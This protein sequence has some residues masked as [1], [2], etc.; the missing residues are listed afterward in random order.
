MDQEPYGQQPK[1]LII[2][3]INFFSFL[4]VNLIIP[5]MALYASTL[6][7]NPGIIGL[8]IGLYSITDTPTNIFSGRL[9]D[10]IGYKLPLIAGLSGGA[11]SMFSYSLTK[12]PIHLALVRAIH[13]IFGGLKSPAI[14]S[15]F[16]KNASESQRGKVMSF[17]GM[18]LATA[19]LVGFSLSGVIVSQLGY[20][21][22]FFLGAAVLAAGVIIGISLP[23]AE[24]Q[25]NT[26][27]TASFSQNYGKMRDLLSRKGLLV[28]F[29]AIF[30]QYFAFGGVVT[31]LPLYVKNLG[32]EA[33]HVGMLLTTFTIVFIIL[34][35]PSGILSDRV[36][37][38]K[39][40]YTGLSLGIVSLII[41]PLVTS[42]TALVM[43]M[44]LY[45]AAFGLLF[46][47]V[48][49]LI[50]DQTTP[51]ERGTANGFFHALLTSGV[52][53]GAPV[54]GGIGNVLG[55]TMGLTLN[56]AILVVALGMCLVI[57][58]R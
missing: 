42:F 23:K 15:A 37:R 47:T 9:I 12:L 3:V 44:T 45:G 51:E 7:A 4:D 40:V 21:P 13:G 55:I 27:T 43:T 10:K 50:T 24:K 32:M 56:P 36:G 1:L 57:M 6:G 8:L 16:T 14:M 28:S 46:P 5:V 34:Q 52:A 22:L 41:L 25:K 53:I 17:Y 54:L 31:L 20:K 18:S 48:S 39:L 49:A 35:F 29:S 2:S 11:V 26:V 58:R 19:N 30:A 38:L 33:F